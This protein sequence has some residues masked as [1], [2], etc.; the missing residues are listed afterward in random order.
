M[1]A[2]LEYESWWRKGRL[3]FGDP[4]KRASCLRVVLAKK[5]GR[6]E[7]N[8]ESLKRKRWMEWQIS[9]W[10]CCCGFYL[11][12]GGSFWLSRAK[13]SLL[14]DFDFLRL[15]R[16]LENPRKSF[17]KYVYVIRLF[18]MEIGRVE[19]L[20]RNFSREGSRDESPRQ[21][22]YIMDIDDTSMAQVSL[23][24]APYVTF[25]RRDKGASSLFFFPSLPPSPLQEIVHTSFILRAVYYSSLIQTVSI[26]D[27]IFFIIE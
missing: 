13:V 8:F 1:L 17:F 6:G 19:Y 16:E 20:V 3:G 23:L 24:D 4:K 9:R 2:D 25:I 27:N 10:N 12:G 21:S 11:D 26:L 18:I 7:E 22:R 14:K 5:E 15:F